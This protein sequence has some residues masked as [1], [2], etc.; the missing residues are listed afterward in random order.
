MVVVA[1]R[2]AAFARVAV[3][4]WRRLGII[5]K[6]HAKA[7]RGGAPVNALPRRNPLIGVQ[8]PSCGEREV[9]G[10]TEGDTTCCE[11]AQTVGHVTCDGFRCRN[12]MRRMQGCGDLCCPT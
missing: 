6:Q 12:T 4:R 10:E 11:A 1:R 9:A 3:L 2:D 5:W 7:C 8:P